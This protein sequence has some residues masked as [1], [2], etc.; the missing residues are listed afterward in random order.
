[1]KTVDLQEEI[2]KEANKYDDIIQSS[3]FID[4]YSEATRKG[5]ALLHWALLNCP[6]AEFVAK[7]DDDCW[8]NTPRFLKV[9][10][11][12]R[13]KQGIFGLFWA[14]GAPVIRDPKNKWNVPFADFPEDNFPPYVSGILYAMSRNA[15][16]QLAEAVTKLKY[17]WHDDVFI[18]GIAAKEAGVQHWGLAGYDAKGTGWK[19]TAC[20][21]SAYLA[22]HYVN[23]KNM[24][25]LWR[26]KCQKYE[27]PC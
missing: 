14:Q 27:V 16:R 2:E 20:A 21:K 11:K 3:A 22:I 26:D 7:A 9:L 6:Q 23:D 18:T 24:E 1:M 19:R 10:K 12:H 13:D 17:L 8:V 25:A 15:V 5:V 4:G